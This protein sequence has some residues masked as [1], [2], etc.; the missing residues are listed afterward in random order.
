M[1]GLLP[2][3]KREL[4]GYFATPVAYVFIVIFLVLTGIFS[5]IGT[6]QLLTALEAD[7]GIRLSAADVTTVR[8]M[9][10]RLS[11]AMRETQPAGTGDRD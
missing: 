1:R 3:F 9:G 10:D 11:A 4:S 2:I 8:A 7:T 5:I 6:L